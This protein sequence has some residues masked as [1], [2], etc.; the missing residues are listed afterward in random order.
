MSAKTNNRTGAESPARTRIRPL[1]LAVVAAA[2]VMVPCGQAFA[3]DPGDAGALFLRIGM[4]ARASAMGEGYTAVAEDASSVYWNPA[5]MAA[6]LNTNLMFAHNESFLSSRLEQVALTHETDYGMIGLMFTGQ[7][8]DKMERREDVPSEIPLGE[9]SVYDVAFAAGFARYIL[10]NLSVGA[11]IKP[12]YQRIDERSSTGLAFDFGVYHVSR[13]EGLRLAAVALNVGTPMKFIEEE[14]ALPRS[15]KV[16]G[17]YD[18]EFEQIRGRVLLTFDGVFV[19]DGDPRQHMGA[20]YTYRRI[21]SLR[22]GYKGG[23]DSYGGTFGAGI[24]YKK[25][26]VDYAFLLVKND[27]GDSHRISVSI[28]P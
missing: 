18:R 11:T 13:I 28:R 9:F 23:Y 25:L 8:M 1:L 20:E 3:S 21:V 27:L 16:G 5:A 26:D 2:V 7:Y 17:S 14:Y 4:G 10:P 22:A 24:R 19:N 15:I 12:V 6:V